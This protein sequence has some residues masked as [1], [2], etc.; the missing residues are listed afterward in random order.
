MQQLVNKPGAGCEEV[1]GKRG[2]M[3]Q[4]DNETMRQSD[5]ETG[6]EMVPVAFGLRVSGFAGG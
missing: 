1:Q 6:S 3:G 2:T 4:S 5:R